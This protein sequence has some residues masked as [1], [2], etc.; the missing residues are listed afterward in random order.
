MH[1]TDWTTTNMFRVGMLT[2]K[3]MEELERLGDVVT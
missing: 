1:T 3:L 2:S